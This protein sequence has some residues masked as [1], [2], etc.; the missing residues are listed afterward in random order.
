M[1]DNRWDDTRCQAIALFQQLPSAFWTAER[2]VAICDNVYDD[3][4]VLGRELVL[5]GFEQGAGDSYL[6]QLS[7]HPATQVQLFVSS[8]LQHY[9]AGKPETIL[10]LQAYFKTVLSQVN[11]G[12][13]IKDR[14]IAFLFNESGQH[15]TVGKMVAELFSDQSL[16]SVVADKARYIKTLFELHQRYGIQQTPVKVIAPE[17]RAY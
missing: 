15:E 12:R 1:L 16:S 4:Q 14:V 5:R 11:R 2:V 9:A 6:L 3:V 8:F 17:V 13:I 10:K 7:Q